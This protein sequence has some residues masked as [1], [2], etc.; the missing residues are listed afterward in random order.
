MKDAL[1]VT[2]LC[3][4]AGGCVGVGPV[5]FYLIMFVCCQSTGILNVGASNVWSVCQ[6]TWVQIPS[7]LSLLSD[8]FDLTSST[9][10]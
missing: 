7:T 6:P 2:L 5:H 4:P 1:S 8:L 9:A 3:I 10:R